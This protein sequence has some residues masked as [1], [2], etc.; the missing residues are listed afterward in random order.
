ML[1]MENMKVVLMTIFFEIP[2]NTNTIILQK[3]KTM[4]RDGSQANFDSQAAESF[5]YWKP[6]TIP[7]N[8][9]VYQSQP[10]DNP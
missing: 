7:N 4:H 9:E 6:G 3:T 1:E 2:L 10:F 8:C 5:P